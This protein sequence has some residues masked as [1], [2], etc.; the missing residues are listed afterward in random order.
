MTNKEFNE[1]CNKEIRRYLEEANEKYEA[2]EKE[3]IYA[4]Y[5]PENDIE[6][7]IKAVEAYKVLYDSETE[8]WEKYVKAYEYTPTGQTLRHIGK[9]LHLFY[10]MKYETKRDIYYHLCKII[11]GE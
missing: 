4:K 9:L 3:R 1:E 8:E 6:I 7:A 10:D 11:G 5:N 2:E